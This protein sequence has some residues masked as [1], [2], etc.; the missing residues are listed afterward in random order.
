MGWRYIGEK[1][2]DMGR[3]VCRGCGLKIGVGT[4]CMG[5]GWEIWVGRIIRDEAERLEH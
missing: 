3:G 5:G 4:V 1:M 2:R